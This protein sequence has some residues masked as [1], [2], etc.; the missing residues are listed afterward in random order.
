LNAA[1]S[2]PREEMQTRMLRRSTIKSHGRAR[3]QRS[4]VALRSS[5]RNLM[6]IS[7]LR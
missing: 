4:L 5:A 7:T 2:F 3:A 6:Q 1:G